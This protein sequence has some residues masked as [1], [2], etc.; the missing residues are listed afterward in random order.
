MYQVEASLEQKKFQFRYMIALNDRYLQI[1]EERNPKFRES[2]TAQ[3]F[4]ARIEYYKK[5]LEELEERD[6]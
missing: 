6:E 3:Q 2:K 1:A 4:L 5:C